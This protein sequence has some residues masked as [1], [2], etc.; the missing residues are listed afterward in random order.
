MVND[1][2]FVPAAAGAPVVADVA[3][4]NSPTR[5]RPHPPQTD[6]GIRSPPNADRRGVITTLVCDRKEARAAE[7]CSSPA[8]IRP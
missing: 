4:K 6:V 5:A 7:V 2:R 1:A 8:L 3:I